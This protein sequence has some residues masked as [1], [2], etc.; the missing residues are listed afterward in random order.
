[1]KVRASN[2]ID[3]DG[4]K[5]HI[6]DQYCL[7]VACQIEDSVWLGQEQS[8]NS[9]KWMAHRTVTVEIP[10]PYSTMKGVVPKSKFDS[11]PGIQMHNY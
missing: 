3:I 8:N 1:M 7:Q 2:Y 4:N 10:R 11:V 6:N 5:Q 9:G